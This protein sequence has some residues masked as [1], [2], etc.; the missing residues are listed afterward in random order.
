[1]QLDFQD[2]NSFSRASDEIDVLGWQFSEEDLGLSMEELT[3]K[4]APIPENWCH[5]YQENYEVEFCNKENEIT[6]SQLSPLDASLTA[7]EEREVVADQVKCYE[8]T[9]EISLD[10]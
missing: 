7:D 5:S 8:F 10:M 4:E 3:V 1:M 2:E 6:R 9:Q